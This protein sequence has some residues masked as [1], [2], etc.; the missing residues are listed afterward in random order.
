MRLRHVGMRD[1]YDGCERLDGAGVTASPHLPR[2][3]G[4]LQQLFVHVGGPMKFPCRREVHAKRFNIVNFFKYRH[5]INIILIRFG[6]MRGCTIFNTK[7][8]NSCFRSLAYRF[9]YVIIDFSVCYRHFWTFSYSLNFS[10][11]AFIQ[12]L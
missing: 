6:L 1:V 2:Q 10:K 12:L 11:L 3:E 9:T 4:H 5:D 7:N 8:V